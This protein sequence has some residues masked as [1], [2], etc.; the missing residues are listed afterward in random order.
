M[1]QG[2][3]HFFYGQNGIIGTYIFAFGMKMVV[4]TEKG[5]KIGVV[6]SACKDHSFAQ[7]LVIFAN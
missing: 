3:T 4:K 6:K 2:L 7:S 1:F 5:S